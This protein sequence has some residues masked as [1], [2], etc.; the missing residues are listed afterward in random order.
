MSDVT[1]NSGYT[2]LLPSATPLKLPYATLRATSHSRKTL[3]EL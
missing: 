3:N 1:P 2:V